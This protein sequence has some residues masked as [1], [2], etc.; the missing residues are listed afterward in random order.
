[1]PVTT[2]SSTPQ[3]GAGSELEVDLA[4][5]GLSALPGLTGWARVDGLSEIPQIGDEVEEEEDTEIHETARR[6]SSDKLPTPTE[7]ELSF[8]QADEP[9]RNGVLQAA[10]D[11]SNLAVRVTYSTGLRR[12]FGVTL[13]GDYVDNAG[14]DDRVMVMIKGKISGAIIKDYVEVPAA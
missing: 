5:D 12:T 2:N 1:M 7:F 4:W 10:I 11:R 3:Y 14:I 9:V 8:K 6:Y 13:L